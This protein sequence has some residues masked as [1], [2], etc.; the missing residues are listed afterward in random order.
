MLGQIISIEETIVK[1]KLAID[2]NSQG[3]LMNLHVV[4]D[5]DKN[6]CVGEIVGI[7]SE[8]MDVFLIGEFVDDKFMTSTFK[9]PS[10]KSRVRMINS[11]ELGYIYGGNTD[12]EDKFYIGR[13]ALYNNY[14]VYA[15]LNDLFSNHLAILGN[16]G[17]GKSYT[18]SRLI[19]NIY[20]N[21]KFP[22]RSSL[23]IFDAYGEYNHAFND[24]NKVVPNFKYKK[25]TTETE[26]PEGDIL[27]IPLCL[28]GTDDLAILLGC[29]SATQIPVIDKALRFAKMF[30][31]GGEDVIKYKNSLLARAILDILISGATPTQTREQVIALLETINTEELNLETEIVQPGYVRNIRQCLYVDAAGK[32]Q[33]VEAVVDFLNDF[34]IDIDYKT[35]DKEVYFDLVNLSEAFDYALISEGILSSDKVYDESNVLRV[36]LRSIINSAKKEYFNYSEYITKEAYVKK[37]LTNQDGSKAQVIN[38][39]MSFV[40]DRLAKALTKII[41]KML[42]S[43]STTLKE[44]GTLPFHIVIEE[45]HRYVQN[46]IDE[47]M[48]GYNIFNRIAKEGRKYGVLL[49]LISQRP[50]E[51][52]PTTI[53]QCSNFL[54]MRML[55]PNDIE[56]VKAMVPSATLEIFERVKQL[57][58]GSLIAF[59]NSF[60]IPA[61]VNVDL[62]NPTPLSQNVDIKRVWY[63]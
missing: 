22:S 5:D 58:P 26:Y 1:I 11:E 51:L 54:I 46:D 13:S 12:N 23:F 45:A 10:F 6:H 63:E 49:V 16:T 31:S 38:F 29:T 40:D 60:K 61:I 35:F 52:S 34:L 37:L 9:K 24:F 39:N 62:P 21:P 44:R 47:E 50:N 42:F 14:K 3:N 53:S 18:V 19:Q 32:S 43:V 4:F 8:Y 15:S 25:Y 56:Y 28:L 33:D 30:A 20:T 55:H 59:G 48:L 17:S 41:S 2:I 36:R 57:D 27:N 7:E